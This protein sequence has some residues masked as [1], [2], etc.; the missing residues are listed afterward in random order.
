MDAFARREKEFCD[1]PPH[2]NVVLVK[3]Q[4]VPASRIDHQLAV[5]RAEQREKFMGIADGGGVIIATMT[6]KDRH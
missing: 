2:G 5:R 3:G 1:M 6:D 4:D